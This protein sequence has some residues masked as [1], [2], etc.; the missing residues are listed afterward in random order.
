M[1]EKGSHS[2]RSKIRCSGVPM[3]GPSGIGLGFTRK[4]GVRGEKMESKVKKMISSILIN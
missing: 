1:E 4:S 2:E 3:V